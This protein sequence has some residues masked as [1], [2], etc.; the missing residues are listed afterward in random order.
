MSTNESYY[1]IVNKNYKKTYR[2]IFLND[3]LI[4]S[5][6]NDMIMNYYL[7]VQESEHD[8]VEY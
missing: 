6:D 8:S 4:I 7:S 5:A 1:C 3:D 2:N